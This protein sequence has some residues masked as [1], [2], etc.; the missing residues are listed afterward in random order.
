MIYGLYMI[1]KDRLINIWSAR[2]PLDQ[3]ITSEYLPVQS[4]GRC[5]QTRLVG[6]SPNQ[7]GRWNRTI[8]DKHGGNSMVSIAMCD[9]RRL[10]SGKRLHS[11]GKSTIL[12]GKSTIDWPFSIAMLVYQRVTSVS[13]KGVDDVWFIPIQS[14]AIQSAPHS[15]PT[16]RPWP[17]RSK[18]SK[19]V[20][21]CRKCMGTE[22]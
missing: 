7:H 13:E 16:C 8:F 18:W 21:T 14:A 22:N 17:D 1:P 6:R 2:N 12:I 5:H 19:A 4:L 9:Y 3:H 20:Q 11:Y 10:P 15:R